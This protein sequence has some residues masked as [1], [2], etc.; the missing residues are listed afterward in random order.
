M[1]R[2]L[3]LRFSTK[4][5]KHDYPYRHI[6]RLESPVVLPS[7]TDLRPVC[8]PIYDQGQEGS[9][10]A[11]AA[12]AHK[13]FLDLKLKKPNI[14]MPSRNFIY[15]CERAL[16]GDT[17]QD[18]GASMRDSVQVLVDKGAC[19]ETLWP[20]TKDTLYV[21]PPPSL[22]GAAWHQR[23]ASYYLLQS[24]IEFKQCLANGYPFVLGMVVYESFMSAQ[25][26]RTGV[27]PIPKPGEALEG[28][29]A[30]MA[31]GYDDSLSMYIIR[32]SWGTQWGQAGYFLMPYAV[33]HDVDLVSDC[34]TV[35]STR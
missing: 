18:A 2:V 22:F 17:Y 12:A 26:A 27:M 1:K 15:W 28:G 11:H 3:N 34:Y 13:Q 21:C 35:R 23:A 5:K 14:I 10:T 25:T 31:V 8:P 29:H 16:D 19:S 30:L 20:Y 9:C 24:E 33:M 6:M 7:K 32:N 4:D